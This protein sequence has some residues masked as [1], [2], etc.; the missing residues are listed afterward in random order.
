MRTNELS[1]LNAARL[2]REA[3]VLITAL[4]GERSHIL[5]EGEAAPEGMED[6][7]RLAFKSGKSALV[8]TGGET[9]F[10]NVYLPPPRVVAIGAVHITQALSGLCADCGL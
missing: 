7:V 5:I 9:L 2:R 3:V 1:V 6:A 8:E 4:S 10:L